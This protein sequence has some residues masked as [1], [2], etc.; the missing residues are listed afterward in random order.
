MSRKEHM[1]SDRAGRGAGLPLGPFKRAAVAGAVIL[2]A[3]QC[4][5]AHADDN[6]SPTTAPSPTPSIAP[7]ST[8]SG[9]ASATPSASPSLAPSG[10]PSVVPSKV[11]VFLIAPEESDQDFMCES[12]RVQ[13]VL[14]YAIAEHRIVS[15]TF[16][17]QSK[18]PIAEDVWSSA[19]GF[20]LT[21]RQNVKI[22]VTLICGN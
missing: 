22:N 11:K 19:Y 3:A 6:A 9:A 20:R 1:W 12:G 5:R 4:I 2:T 14:A 10:V 18:N 17:D 8:P 13:S 15:I 21:H 16:L 7:S